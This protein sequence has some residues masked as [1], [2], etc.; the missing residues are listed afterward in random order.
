MMMADGATFPLQFSEALPRSDKER[1]IKLKL[2]F[3]ILLFAMTLTALSSQI[4]EGRQA[5]APKSKLRFIVYG[6]TRDGHSIHRKLVALILK[7]KPDL[8]I[9]TGDLVSNASDPAQWKTYDS[10]TGEMRKK[11]P[12]YPVRGNHDVGAGYLPRFTSP[13]TSGNRLYYSFEKGGSHFIGLD[14]TASVAK[15]SEQYE[16]L[17]NDLEKAKR[18]K[19]VFVSFHVPPYG[20]GW[21]GS[22]LGVRS[23]LCPLFIKYGVRGVFNGHDHNYYRTLR[24]GVTYITSGGGGATPFPPDPSKGAI[25]GDK[26]ALAFHVVLCEVEGDSVKLTAINFDGKPF[27]EYVFPSDA[28]EK[29]E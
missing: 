8:V 20:I 14:T 3:F 6:D 22:D 18:A 19:H 26:Y 7:L 1:H 24:N 16:W 28:P 13:I 17:E 12:V 27:D 10:I 4:S 11:L 29:P 15:G 2:A 9:Q 23:S 5:A 21:H 25:K